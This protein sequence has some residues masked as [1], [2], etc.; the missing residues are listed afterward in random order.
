MLRIPVERSTE[1]P[2][3]IFGKTNLDSSPGL[4]RT[5]SKPCSAL[6]PHQHQQ[7][8]EGP[9]QQLRP[10]QADSLTEGHTAPPR[11]AVNEASRTE[12]NVTPNSFCTEKRKKSDINYKL[13]QVSLFFN[14]NI[15]VKDSARLGTYNKNQSM[16][17]RLAG[18]A[19]SDPQQG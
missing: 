18:L 3:I 6:P 13:N 10:S 17:K 19:L 7:G 12:Q 8:Q 11:Q 5:Q 1:L 4:R 14:L 2:L 16:Q 9:G 15:K